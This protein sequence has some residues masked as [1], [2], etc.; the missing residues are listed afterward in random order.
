MKLRLTLIFSMLFS[1]ILFAQNRDAV[2]IDSEKYINYV[3]LE[4]IQTKDTLKI[5]SSD[6]KVSKKT[7]LQISTDKKTV[8]NMLA[9]ESFD[10]KIQQF[11]ADGS[12]SYIYS[13]LTQKNG[14]YRVTIDFNKYAIETVKDS[15]TSCVGYV[16]MGIALRVV[17]NLYANKKKVN[18]NNVVAIAEAAEKGDIVGS[19]GFQIL[20]LESE[21]I[22]AVTPLESELT[23]TS[24]TQYFEALN[25]LRALIYKPETRLYPQVIAI[26]HSDCGFR[27]IT[28]LLIGKR[29]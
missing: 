28:N 6:N 25:N 29:N 9:N 19:I 26:K 14:T 21:E 10:T 7:P 23:S 16:K 4:A 11:A 2:N 12:I 22:A 5:V 3:P 1:S 24:H 20:G 27:D 8:T 13:G 18:I 15:A 17:I